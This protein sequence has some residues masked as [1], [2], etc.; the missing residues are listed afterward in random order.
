MKKTETLPFNKALRTVRKRLKLTLEE[1]ARK[2]GV[3][4]SLIYSYESGRRE[5]TEETIGNI[6]KAL[7]QAL[8]DATRKEREERE[9]W[10]SP[11]ASVSSGIATSDPDVSRALEQYCLGAELTTDSRQAA[12]R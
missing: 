5:P 1:F 7:I 9:Q 6:K 3:S 12:R 4:A 8:A 2:A 11:L 10:V